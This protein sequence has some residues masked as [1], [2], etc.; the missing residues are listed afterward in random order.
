MS[1]LAKLRAGQT[2]RGS[3]NYLIEELEPEWGVSTA[4]DTRD[5]EKQLAALRF[6]AAHQV[7]AA[8]A[9]LEE[10]RTAGTAEKQA[11]NECAVPLLRASKAHV[12]YSMA[13]FFTHGV[14][15]RLEEEADDPSLADSGVGS[16]MRELRDLFVLQYL[17][18]ASGYF[19]RSRYMRPEQIDFIDDEVARSI[20]IIRGNAV[21]LVDSF[22]L[23]DFV[24]NSP[25]GRYD[26]VSV[27]GGKPHFA[28]SPMV[29]LPCSACMSTTSSRCAAARTARAA[30][31][32]LRQ[33]SSRCSRGRTQPGETA[34]MRTSSMYGA[35]YSRAT[36][37]LSYFANFTPPS[38]FSV[39][40]PSSLICTALH[41]T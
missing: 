9:A 7:K 36:R 28:I 22:G 33:L 38:C 40:V 37:T 10:A 26:G 6:H 14:Q 18:D 35:F 20:K 11:W 31:L 13:S 2:V 23:S 21:A 15:E 1:S 27:R 41:T 24:L 5:P 25:L 8:S 32:T 16:I 17:S 19:L 3:V 4:A 39:P 12:Y 34:R 30:L 29:A